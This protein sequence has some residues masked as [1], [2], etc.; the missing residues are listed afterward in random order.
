MRRFLT[1]IAFSGGFSGFQLLLMGVLIS[2]LGY[3]SRLFTVPYR[4]GF[5]IFSVIAVLYGISTRT[6]AKLGRLW[7]P[8][9]IFWLLYFIRIAMDGYITPVSLRIE[10]MEYLQKA[11]GAA[12]IPMFIF[13]LRLDNEQNK[14][15]FNSFWIVLGGC[16][17]AAISFYG[18]FLHES[19]RFL[20]YAGVD[21]AILMGPIGLAYIGVTITV[22]SLQRSVSSVVH[23]KM[24]AISLL[25]IAGGAILIAV[26]GT[27]SALIAFFI[28]CSLIIVAEYLTSDRQKIVFSSIFIVFGGILIAFAMNL[29]G[30]DTADR[31]QI[32]IQKLA[33][34]DPSTGGG[35]LL[36][37][38]NTLEQIFQNPLLG[39][40]LEEKNSQF[41]PHNHILEAFMAT[42]VLGG[43]CFCI[44][45]WHT[46]K[47]C[48]LIL[49]KEKSYGWIPCVFIV[50]FIHGLFSSSIID[51]TLWYSM[52]AVYAVPIE[53]PTSSLPG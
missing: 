38:Q 4:A 27:R 19:Y 34:G 18:K 9:L 6:F 24:H 52:M 48:F 47:R 40:G 20:T 37:Y 51:S 12:F 31:Y 29:Y 35:R 3:A 49:L 16:L 2:G 15:A 41:Y 10:P 53:E 43:V 28:A 1:I 11:A 17:L 45:C 13:L 46:I 21:S 8:L 30:A 14:I 50:Y 39:S 5:L 42:G 22:I 25:S 33:V 26:S 36:L 32:L 44:L 7:T 23:G